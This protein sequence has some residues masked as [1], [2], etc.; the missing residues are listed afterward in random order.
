MSSSGSSG[1]IWGFFERTRETVSTS[2]SD[3]TLPSWLTDLKSVSG[4]LIEFGK[5][6]KGFILST[7]LLILIEQVLGFATATFAGSAGR[8]VLTIGL[9]AG[10][11]AVF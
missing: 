5:D 8:L 9:A 1:G 11:L 10:F 3:L 2:W 4:T 7:L 6:P